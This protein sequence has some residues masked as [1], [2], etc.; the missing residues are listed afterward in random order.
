MEL[1]DKK[2]CV[3]GV[4]TSGIGAVKLL[5]SVGADVIL[6]DGNGKLNPEDIK[7]KLNGLEASIVLGEMP[8]SLLDTLDL[9]VI[10]PGV[11]I[12][13]PIVLQMNDANIPVWGEIELAYNYEKGVVAAITGT[14]GKTT[15]T[16]LLGEIVKGFGKD[17][18]V[19]GN[20]GN[21]YT[22][23]V[24]NTTSESYTVAEISSF[25]LE[26]VFKFKPAVSGILNITPDHLNR[27]YTMENYAATKERLL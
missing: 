2:V 3:V 21:S 17:T 16:A 15:T 12:D 7:A 11:P 8:Q 23:E 6:Y 4:G 14:N 18:F 24:Q 22:G 10:S 25:Q 27:H 9:T 20:I 1:R 26:T 19:V 13:S 5:N